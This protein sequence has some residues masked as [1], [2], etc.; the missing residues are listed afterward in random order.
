MR[1]NETSRKHSNTVPLYGFHNAQD[2]RSFRLFSIDSVSGIIRTAGGERVD[3]ESIPL[4]IITV[5]ARAREMYT[6]TRLI[7]HI[8]D[9][10]DKG[11]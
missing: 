11:E 7:I 6:F 1:L 3:R 5:K 9:E 2:S 4:H 10:N 8:L